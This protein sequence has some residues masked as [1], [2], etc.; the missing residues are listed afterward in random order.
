M[1]MDPKQMPLKHLDPEDSIA[2][3]GQPPVALLSI[4]SEVKSLLN[5][6]PNARNSVARLL[7]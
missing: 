4:F 6:N 5:P 2:N 3:I 1:A 7:A